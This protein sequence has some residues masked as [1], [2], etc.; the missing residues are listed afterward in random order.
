MKKVLIYSLLALAAFSM[1]SCL[2]EQEDLFEESS[3]KRVA[4][5]IDKTKSTLVSAENGWL[6]EIY[7]EKT[8]RY[9]GYAFVLKFDKDMQVTIHSELSEDITES[10]TSFYQVSSE[11]GPV[12][13]FDTYNPLQHFFATPNSSRYQAYEGEVEY[14]VC[15]VKSDLITL[16]GCKTSN[17]MY[18]RK[19]TED[20]VSYLTKLLES[21]DRIVMSGFTGT[22]GS[23]DLVGE[24][25]IDN[26]Q[27][28]V[29]AGSE[30]SN[31]AYTVVPEGI[32]FYAPIAVGTSDINGLAIA[33]DG[34]ITVS[35][36]S[37]KGTNFK[38]VYPKG[39]R[40]YDAY[41]GKYMFTFSTGTFPVELVPG[42]EGQTY[43]MR[44][45]CGYDA[46]GV[47]HRDD[48]PYDMILA[49]SKAKGN[50]TLALQNFTKDGEPVQYN[51]KYIG[52]TPLAASNTTGTSGYLAFTEGAGMVTDWNG[53]EENPAYKLIS[54]GVYSRPIDTYWLAQYTGPTQTS[55]TRS[56]GSSLPVEFKFF[57][58]T[59]IM[60]QPS[61]LVKVKE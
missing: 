46:N 37:A 58:K 25:D 12:L 14:V 13:I 51:G 48:E 11:D 31:V 28:A 55:T 43:I 7:P 61:S 52:I 3:S 41:A 10:E 4:D 22:V 60:F 5:M 27:V 20:A 44:G 15:D 33:D 26:R 35:E 50:L 56:S 9:G 54:N 23:V 57:G 47:Y 16:R 2:Y 30:T 29:T 8:Q 49:Y 34:S 42:V 38:P 18:L 6:M 1:Q 53:D 39:F 24:I 36:G 32:R 59:H 40:T 17:I 45:I 21:D 19:M